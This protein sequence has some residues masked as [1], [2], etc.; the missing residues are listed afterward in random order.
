MIDEKLKYDEDLLEEYS[1]QWRNQWF[2]FTGETYESFFIH[3]TETAAIKHGNKWLRERYL[4]LPL[5]SGN[6]SALGRIAQGD[7]V[8]HFIPMPIGGT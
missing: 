4:D 2:L 1:G 6:T 5:A 7:E 3:G 8:S